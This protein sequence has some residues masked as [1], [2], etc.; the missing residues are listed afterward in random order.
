MRTDLL[1][2]ARVRWIALFEAALSPTILGLVASMNMIGRQGDLSPKPGGYFRLNL[3]ERGGSAAYLEGGRNRLTFNGSFYASGHY[4]T[5][6]GSRRRVIEQVRKL[7]TPL[8]PTS[9][10]DSIFANSLCFGELQEWLGTLAPAKPFSEQSI[11][12]YPLDPGTIDYSDY[13]PMHLAA[14]IGPPSLLDSILWGLSEEEINTRSLG[15]SLLHVCSAENAEYLINLGMDVNEQIEDSLETPL[16]QAAW[17]DDL[18][19]IAVLLQHGADP[20][21]TDSTGEDAFDTCYSPTSPPREA[22]L[23]MLKSAGHEQAHIA[24]MDTSEKA[25]KHRRVQRSLNLFSPSF[26]PLN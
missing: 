25:A 13:T 19:K 15:R 9:E 23:K 5:E 11:A 17:D 12:D 7:H 24:P 21:I 26:N 16:H 10:L 4:L 18:E 3:L 6:S 14:G 8:H 2:T 20:H 1:K 22:T